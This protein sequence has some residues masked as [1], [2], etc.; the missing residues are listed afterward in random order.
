MGNSKRRFGDCDPLGT[1][2]SKGILTAMTSPD[3]LRDPA[4]LAEVKALQ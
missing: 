3:P 4:S 2:R 1:Q